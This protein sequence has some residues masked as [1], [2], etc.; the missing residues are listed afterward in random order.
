MTLRYPLKAAWCD[1]TFV[2]NRLVNCGTFKTN[3]PNYNELQKGVF[4]YNVFVTENG[5]PFITKGKNGLTD[6]DVYIHHNTVIG[7]PLISV[8]DSTVSWVPRIFDNVV[9]SPDGNVITETGTAFASGNFSSFKTDG[10]AFFRNNAYYASALNGGTATEVSGYD[11]SKGLLVEDNF[12]LA[13]APVFKS[14]NPASPDFYRPKQSKNP[15]WIGKH[16]AWTNDGEYPDYIGAVKPQVP[17]P[18]LLI[19]VR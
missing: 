9:S 3:V 13:A 10:G 14:T 12:V 7:G 11:L 16:L 1:F 6:K 18:G 19:I 8:L 4:A 5:T 17:V 15:Q 2:S